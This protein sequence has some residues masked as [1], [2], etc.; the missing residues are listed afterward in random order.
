MIIDR[1]FS[2]GVDPF[3][4]SETTERE[5]R[6]VGAD[7]Q[8][9]FEQTV[10]APASWSDTA[11]AVVAQKYFR[12]QAGTPERES[13]VY[14]LVLRVSRAIA[15]W[16]AVDGYFAAEDE[17]L[18]RDELFCLLI[19]QY[20][21]FNSPV[22]FNVG[23]EEH[24]QASACFISRVDDSLESILDEVKTEGVIF[25]RGSGVGT[26]LSRLRSSKEHLSGGGTA[27]GPVSF[28]RGYD[29]MAGVIKS[30]GKTRRSAIMRILN[31]DH[32]D[33]HEFIWCKAKENKK[34]H[35]LLDAGFSGGINGEAASSI[36][37]QNAN[38]S[39][40]ITDSFMNAVKHDRFWPLRDRNG[41]V[42]EA[43]LARSL[44]REIAQ[45]AWECGDPGLQ[46]HD[47][48]N[49]MHTCPNDGEQV[50]TNPC[51]EYCWLDDTSCNL[52]SLNLVRFMN[53]DAD[54]GFDDFAFTRAVRLLI[55]AQDILVSNASYPTER[56]AEQTKRYRTLGL[57]F[58]NLG[59]LL[60]RMG[61]PYDSEEGREVAASIAS[62]MTAEAYRASADIASEL[63]AF[64][65]WAANADDMRRVIDK[66]EFSHRDIDS[67]TTNV[68]ARGTAAWD[69]LQGYRGGFRNAQVTVLA[70]TGT[71]AF[72]M[73]CDTTGI[74]PELSLVKHKTLAGGGVLTTTCAAVKPALANLGYSD[75]SVDAIADYVRQHGS[76]VG[77]PG[78]SAEDVEVFDCALGDRALSP[79]A[80]V[81]MMAAVQPFISGAI[82]KTVN[83]PSDA[84]VDDVVEVFIDAWQRGIKA[85][86]IYRDGSK[87]SQPMSAG[88]AKAA[89][90]P[91][92]MPVRRKLPDTRQSLTHKFS[93]AGHEGY[94]TIGLYDDGQPGELFVTMSKEGSTISGLV[95]SF[96]IAFSHCLQY[97][98]P[99]HDLVEKFRQVRFEPAG[100]TAHRDIR[101]A[102][103]VVD[104]I[105]HFLEIKFLNKTESEQIPMPSVGVTVTPVMPARYADG[106][107]C[108]ACGTLTER[109]GSCYR[110]PACGD[111]T[112]CS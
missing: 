75:A 54:E 30:G 26:N 44:F 97:G 47:T 31:D 106:P 110:C 46:F 70:P 36:A 49:R 32:P 85:I 4:A 41:S 95:D 69:Q 101:F 20:A 3:L 87:G 14:G 66:H 112:G 48:I 5:A 58:A 80:H 8:P 39:V 89:N 18:F 83:V 59:S 62:L 28:M 77:A 76:V 27:S 108:Q 40:R 10:T 22:W 15:K 94:L 96:A 60:M 50:A 103:S 78:V 21:A 109:S 12:G 52:A 61:L 90:A 107:P 100:I 67:V 81:S 37:F 16:G 64:E 2:L 63:G 84:T 111:T 17:S 11:V 43:V 53:P 23:V 51:S 73:D 1:F 35:A 68:V 98:V 79:K 13:S 55:V 74:E 102:T 25:K 99:L 105:A 24:P 91:T 56:I 86:A 57:G 92:P 6:I 65:A 104:Y 33:L 88:T 9:I 45:A 82:S 34:E 42:V 38:N 71:I 72:M 19:N 29:A 93:I 7:G